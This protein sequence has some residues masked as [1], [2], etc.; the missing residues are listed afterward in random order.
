MN[1]VLEADMGLA[2]EITS[3]VVHRGNK[4]ELD[5][6]LP[7]VYAELR[8]LA[9]SSLARERMG[10]TLQPTALV[11]EAY[12]RLMGQREVDW[13]NRAQML[14]IAAQLMRRILAQHAVRRSAAKRGGGVPLKVVTG[15]FEVADGEKPGAALDVVR[16]N[17]ALDKLAT[18]DEQEARIVEL[19]YFGGLTIEETAE[20]LGISPATVKREWKLARAWLLREL[21]GE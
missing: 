13:G 1:T 11:H 17:T 19:R 2:E 7:Q 16:V 21:A 10:H 14:G 9:R 15:P 20:F 18:V 5:A 3:G 4:A 6:I 8:R 12:V